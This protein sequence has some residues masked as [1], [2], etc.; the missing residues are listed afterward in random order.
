MLAG[1]VLLPALLP[2]S[3]PGRVGVTALL[4]LPAGLLMGMPFPTALRTLTGR[5]AAL[6]PGLWSANG[7][8]STLGSV[9]TMALA[10]FIGYGGALLVVCP[11]L[12]L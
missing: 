9:L 12:A 11:C 8:T 4:L 6:I 2:L 3:L 5:D 10:K 7:V 1:W